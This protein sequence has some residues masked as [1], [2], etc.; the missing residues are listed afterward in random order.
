MEIMPFK[1]KSNRKI[2]NILKKGTMKGIGMQIA[3]LS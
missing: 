2:Y 1:I 3:V